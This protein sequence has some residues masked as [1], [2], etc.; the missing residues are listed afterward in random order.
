MLSERCVGDVQ[1]ECRGSLVKSWRM[2]CGGMLCCVA[3]V[4]PRRCRDDVGVEM[5]PHGGAMRKG[6]YRV[7][8]RCSSKRGALLAKG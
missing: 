6:M 4:V 3:V 7:F 5:E 1:V 8:V 2:G